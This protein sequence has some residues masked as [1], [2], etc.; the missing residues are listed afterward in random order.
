M[1]RLLILVAAAALAA[2]APAQAGKVATVDLGTSYYAPAKLTVEQG[3]QGP[4][5]VEPQL[6][7]ARRQR[8]VGAA[9]VQVTTP[10]VGY[11]DTEVHQARQYVLYCTQHSDMGMTLKVKKSLAR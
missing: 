5:Q 7:H 2:A 9:A 1:R 8:E 11:V 10:G 3:R 4:L 6:R